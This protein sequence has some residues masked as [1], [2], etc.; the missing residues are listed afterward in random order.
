MLTHQHFFFG[1]VTRGGRLHTSTAADLCA[2]PCRMGR[3]SLEAYHI[4]GTVNM[5]AM[6][7]GRG[8]T[9]TPQLLLNRPQ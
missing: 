9:V 4:K 6:I 3:S 7:V 8:L 5:N 1:G 2:V